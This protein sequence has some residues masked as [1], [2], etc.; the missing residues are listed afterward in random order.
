MRSSS[1]N[2]VKDGGQ[3]KRTE[4]ALSYFKCAYLVNFRNV[5]ETTA[6]Q[7]QR[8]ISFIQKIRRN[9]KSI[10]CD[11]VPVWTTTSLGREE[12][13][14][15]TA[16]SIHT[17][18]EMAHVFVVPLRIGKN[19]VGVHQGRCAYLLYISFVEGQPSYLKN[20]QIPSAIR[21]ETMNSEYQFLPL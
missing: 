18:I 3:G 10:I 11:T 14:T 8:K 7:T 17:N 1:N 12:D 9:L 20:E 2:H 21:S 6:T 19:E 4:W 16:F 5:Q 15:D 13:F